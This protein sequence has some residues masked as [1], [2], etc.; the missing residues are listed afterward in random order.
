MNATRFAIHLSEQGRL[1]D[2]VVRA[3]I[4]RLLARRLDDLAAGDAEGQAV[5]IE[6]FVRAMA[7]APVAPLPALANAVTDALAPL[8]VAVDALPL[9]PD[10]ILA[11]I[12]A[13]REPRR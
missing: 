2:V 13:A 6:A 7:D 10:R 12:D 8:G 11:L 5:R 3:G 4:R 9:S 1:P